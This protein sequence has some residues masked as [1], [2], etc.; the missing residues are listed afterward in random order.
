VNQWKDTQAASC[1][2]NIDRLKAKITATLL[3]PARYLPMVVASNRVMHLVDCLGEENVS[4]IL[5]DRMEVED[6]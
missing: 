1:P 3:P 2:R 4:A 6:K 5:K